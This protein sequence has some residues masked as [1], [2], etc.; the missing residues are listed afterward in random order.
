MKKYLLPFAISLLIALFSATAIN[1][2]D[3]Q[4]QMSYS[5]DKPIPQPQIFGKGI[6]STGDYDTHPAFSPDGNTL[7]FLKC[8]AE[9]Q[10]CTICVSQFK[11][12]KWS[13]P[14]VAPF[15]GQYWDIDPFVSKD[16]KT[17]YFGSNRPDNVGE[18]AKADT[19]I[20]KVDIINDG[21]GKPV[22]LDSVINSN[23]NEYYPTLADNGTIYFGSSRHGGKGG[24]DIYRCR[25]IDGKYTEA[26]NLGDS[27]NTADDE[28]EPFIASDESY[29][30]FMAARP[31]GLIFGDLYF[32]NKIN[33]QWAKAEKLPEP[34]NS[35]GIEWA[36][37][38]TRDGKYLFFASTRNT[39]TDIP[40]NPE[41]IE[42]LTNR[43]RNTG[44]GLA[45]IYQVD[46]STV[47]RLMD[48]S[49]T[50]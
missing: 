38:V 37:K 4:E 32:S 12:H 6:I 49:L 24:S 8:T 22:R 47:K 16:G 15:S 46:F 48:K 33:G 50:N 10:T 20:W 25:L 34:F 1:S 41:N 43:L 5:S 21:W 31:K 44:N 29:L 45:D 30:I 39:Q 17:L 14:I 11:N 19:D 26:E 42:Q 28:F 27:I 35:F 13:E 36:P 2:I 18:A 23:R 9:I 40:K 3:A 7:Y